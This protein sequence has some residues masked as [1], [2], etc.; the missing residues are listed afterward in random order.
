LVYFIIKRTAFAVLTIWVVITI[1]FILMHN[2]PGRPFAMTKMLPAQIVDNLKE[3]YGL[4]KPIMEQYGIY[5]KNLI[6][7]DFGVSMKYANRSVSSIIIRA[8]PVSAALG[9]EALLIAVFVGLPMGILAAIR[10]NKFYDYSVL[11]L[12]ILFISVPGFICG[13]LFQ[14][15]LCF[16][17]SAL[18]RSITGSDYHLF[19][20][21][22]WGSF[23][24]SI[25]PALALS[26]GITGIVIRMVRASTIDVLNKDFILAARARGLNKKEIIY[27]HV[28]RNSI[29]PVISMMGPM[30]ASIVM[31]SFVI[32]GIFSVPGLGSYVIT[33]VQSKD[34]TMILGI[35]LFMVIF[36][37]LINTI[38]DIVYNLL[39]PRI[40]II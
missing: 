27:R 7:G 10:R 14:Y 31:G 29:L 9:L 16:K 34:Y 40:R 15:F 30:I 36:V 20:T 21:G 23:R 24:D 18:I 25:V 33:S 13:T 6:T 2:L 12:S 38:S 4:N 35:S 5:I 11:V 26:I 8:L 22:G 19:S 17:F 28:L 32:E 37:V 3:N 1:S 39:E